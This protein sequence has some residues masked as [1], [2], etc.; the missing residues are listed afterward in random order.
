MPKQRLNRLQVNALLKVPS[1]E[2]GTELMRMGVLH[3]GSLGNLNAIIPTV[4]VLLSPLELKIRL[5]M[6]VVNCLV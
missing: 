5:E 3:L 6:K 1:C 2:R 4:R